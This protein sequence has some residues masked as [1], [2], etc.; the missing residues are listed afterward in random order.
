MFGDIYPDS[1][2]AWKNDRSE[3]RSSTTNTKLTSPY[4]GNKF[5]IHGFAG[6]FVNFNVISNTCNPIN[7][8]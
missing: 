1:G 7:V 5:G 8:S 6:N 4:P 3:E 2:G